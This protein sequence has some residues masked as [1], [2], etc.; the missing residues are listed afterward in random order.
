MAFQDPLGS[1]LRGSGVTDF[2]AGPRGRR[3]GWEGDLSSLYLEG[4]LPTVGCREL[5]S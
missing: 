2:W 3:Y 1:N 5:S 4:C